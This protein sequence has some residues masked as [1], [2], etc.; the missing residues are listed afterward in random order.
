MHRILAEMAQAGYASIEIG[1][2]RIMDFY[3][4]EVFLG[5]CVKEGLHVSGI[6][7]P[8][9]H[10]NEGDLDYAKQAADYSQAV[11][12]NFMLVSGIEGTSKSQEEFKATADVLNKVGE[13]C[14]EHGLTYLY[15]NHWYEIANNAEELHALCNLTEPNLVS[16]CLDIGWVERSGASVVEVTTEFLDRIAYFHLK[17]SKGERFVSLG[18]GTV[19]FPGWFAVIQGKG[20]F[21]LT[22]ERDEFLPT[23]LESAIRTR[24]FLRSLGL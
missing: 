4:P 10:Y 15:H 23:A 22:Y 18:D 11:E 19:D 12:T 17:D 8:I 1:A 5:M 6:H 13:I 16:L 21:Y 24:K 14:Q 7:T 9:R 3:N 2:Q 20:D